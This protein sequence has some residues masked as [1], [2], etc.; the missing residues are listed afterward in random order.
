MKK[1]SLLL[2][3]LLLGSAATAATPV[4]T[5]LEIRQ[6]GV[7][8]QQWDNSCAA[9][10]LA[11][12]L[13]Y[14]MDYFVSE[15]QVALGMLNKTDP[16]RVRHRGGFSLLDMKNY[17]DEIGFKGEG[18]M[19][20]SIDDLAQ[21]LPAIVPINTR[22]FNHFVVVREI[23]ATDIRIAD[24]SFGNYKLSRNAF[25]TIWSGIGFVFASSGEN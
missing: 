25:K 12:V 8:I 17:V 24:P 20:L 21:R 9:A 2:G 19:S 18:Y 1:L 6:K 14:D 16:L 4:R 7:V 10:A 11:T 13:R 15:E 3:F 23:D 22:G 5:L